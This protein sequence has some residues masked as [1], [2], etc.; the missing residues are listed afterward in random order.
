MI[1]DFIGT[2]L[3]VPFCPY[4]FVHT[5]LSNDILSVYHF[6]C[7]IL[8]VPFYPRTPLI[9]AYTNADKYK[10]KYAYAWSRY[11]F[12]G[13]IRPVCSV[14]EQYILYRSEVT[15]RSVRFSPF[16]IIST[17]SI[18]HRDVFNIA[19]VVGIQLS[20]P[21]PSIIPSVIPSIHP[22]VRVFV[23][24]CLPLSPPF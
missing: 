18:S 12:S 11:K 4:H 22:S 16:C 13:N 17:T 19:V 3:F 23:R 21:P 24:S 10:N 6:V 5:I 14:G 7:T 9:R 2:V 8:S 15:T 1:D 20:L